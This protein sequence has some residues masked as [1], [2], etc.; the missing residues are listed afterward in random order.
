VVRVYY[1]RAINCGFYW[2]LIGSRGVNK[3]PLR[4]DQQ[5]PWSVPC[6]H[7]YL[8]NSIFA[9][10]TANGTYYATIYNVPVSFVNMRCLRG[11]GRCVLSCFRSCAFTVS[12]TD[13]DFDWPNRLHEITILYVH[14]YIGRYLTSIHESGERLRTVIVFYV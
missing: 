4:G 2:F 8:F 3:R 9:C 13:T 14:E 6:T 7:T 10:T 11:T 1:R 5:V 12:T